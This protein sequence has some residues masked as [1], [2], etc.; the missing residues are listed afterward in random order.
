MT[1]WTRVDRQILAVA[2]P[3]FFALVAEPLMLMV[4]TAIV[5]HLGT[6]ELAGLAAASAVLATVVGVC[7]FLAYGSTAAVSRSHGAGDD[8]AALHR[9]RDALQHFEGSEVLTHLRN[10]NGRHEISLQSSD[11][12]ATAESKSRNRP[13]RSSYRRGTVRK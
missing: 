13:R 6:S 11:R 2:V 8:R 3:A 10:S 12:E 1:G 7:V 4:D 9:Q 5:G